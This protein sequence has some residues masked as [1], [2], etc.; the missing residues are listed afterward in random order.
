MGRGCEVSLAVA[1]ACCPSFCPLFPAQDRWKT[2]VRIFPASPS[3]VKDL[4]HTLAS[5][6]SSQDKSTIPP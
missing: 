2:L 5:C 1:H 6:G 3:E 4:L